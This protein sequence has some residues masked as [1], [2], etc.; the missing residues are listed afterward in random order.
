MRKQIS[1]E[2]LWKTIE[3]LTD[4]VDQLERAGVVVVA[5]AIQNALREAC[6][7]TCQL[8]A[9]TNKFVE[10]DPLQF[11]AREGEPCRWFHRFS[12]TKEVASTCDAWKIQ[13]LIVKVK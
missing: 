1:R 6:Q 10:P 9:G 2:A 5:E 4:T 11:Y 3:N 12:D 7:A 13:D 8:C